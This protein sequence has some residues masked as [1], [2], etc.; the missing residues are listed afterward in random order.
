MSALPLPSLLNRP[1]EAGEQAGS[2]LAALAQT[3]AQSVGPLTQHER[4]L[5]VWQASQVPGVRVYRLL[6]HRIVIEDRSGDRWVL[7]DCGH[8]ELHDTNQ[9]DAFTANCGECYRD[10]TRTRVDRLLRRLRSER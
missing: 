3:L 2:P 4:E 5:I 10:A 6:K 1:S 8:V 9:I 7:H